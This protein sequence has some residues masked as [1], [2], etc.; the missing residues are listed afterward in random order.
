MNRVKAEYRTTL[1][2]NSAWL[3]INVATARSAFNHVIT[4]RCIPVDKNIVQI[5]KDV[6]FN[7]SPEQESEMFWSDQPCLHSVSKDWPIPTI[8]VAHTSWYKANR[9][10]KSTFSIGELARIYKNI[11]QIC[12]DKFKTSDLTRE[13]VIPKK[14]GGD[15]CESNL[16][17]T[18]KKCNSLKGDL[19]PYFDANGVPLEKK[20]KKISSVVYTEHVD[21][22]PEWEQFGFAT[23]SKS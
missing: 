8:M 5:P 21:F 11:C 17:P 20:V 6:W 3:P 4:G 18:C 22:R 16:L 10:R 14:L 23:I 9:S 7:A 12:G 13:H 19:F 1:I 2:L 15:L